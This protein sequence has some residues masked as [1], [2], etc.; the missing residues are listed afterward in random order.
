MLKSASFVI[1]FQCIGIKLT[2]I[3][4]TSS[5]LSIAFFISA[6]MAS[7]EDA[8]RRGHGMGK[9]SVPIKIRI[10]FSLDGWVRYAQANFPTGDE[11]VQGVVVWNVN[12]H[13]HAQQLPCSS[14]R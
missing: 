13:R 9:L 10:S 6:R 4:D 2:L 7:K 8:S 3:M 11:V 5:S 14:E 12:L 1:G